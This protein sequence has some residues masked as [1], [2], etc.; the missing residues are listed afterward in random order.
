MKKTGKNVTNIKL[1]ENRFLPKVNKFKGK[2]KVISFK[3]VPNDIN[4]SLEYILIFR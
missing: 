2:I 1:N 4:I 3:Q